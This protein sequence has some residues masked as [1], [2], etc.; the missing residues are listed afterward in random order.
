[1]KTGTLE[2]LCEDESKPSDKRL[3]SPLLRIRYAEVRVIGFAHMALGAEG[4]QFVSFLG[5]VNRGVRWQR[6]V[7]LLSPRRR[8]CGALPQLSP[9]SLSL[10]LGPIPEPWW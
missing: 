3:T 9:A 8:V 7:S 1:M 10:L 4:V 2:H 6:H 5:A